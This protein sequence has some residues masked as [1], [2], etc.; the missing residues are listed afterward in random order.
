MMAID[1]DCTVRHLVLTLGGGGGTKREG[2]EGGRT[3]TN[4]RRET[5]VKAD[6]GYGTRGRKGENPR[7][8]LSVSLDTPLRRRAAKAKNSSL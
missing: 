7:A 1:V 2:G 6:L 5:H 3:W 8:L 4:R